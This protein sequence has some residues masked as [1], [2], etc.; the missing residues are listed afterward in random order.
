MSLDSRTANIWVRAL[1]LCQ[2]VRFEIGGTMTLVGV[3]ADRIVVAP[4]DGELVIPRLAI[5]SVVAGLTGATKIA[6]CQT[7]S[8]QGREFGEVI[9]HGNEPHDGTVDEHRFVNIVSPLWLPDAGCYR[10]AA[11]F[12]TGEAFRTVEHHLIVERAPAQP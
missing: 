9:A 10:L 2:D 8:Q 1:I 11:D 5:Y 3:Y 7:L 6:W 12:E 4:T